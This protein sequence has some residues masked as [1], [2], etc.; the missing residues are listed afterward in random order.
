MTGGNPRPKK[1]H[2]I[3]FG[4]QMNVADSELL[5]GILR[6]K[7]LDLIG[8]P[9]EA[10]LIV[11]NTCT[12]RRKAEDKAYSQMGRL[13]K[14]KS[15][16]GP[17]PLVAMAGCVAKK[18]GRDL[19]R[20]FPGLDIVLSP[21]RVPRVGDLLDRRLETGQAV[22]D[23]GDRPAGAVEASPV[24]K[25]EVKAFVNIMHGCDNHCAYC[26]V[27]AVRGPEVS[28]PPGDVLEEVTELADRGYGEVTLLGQNVNSYGKGLDEAIDFPGLLERLD[29]RSGM[30]RLRFTTSHPKDFDSRLV[31]AIRDLPSVCEAVHLPVQAGSDRVLRAMNRK[32]GPGEYRDK[33]NLL[34]E[35]V[36][37]VRISTDII[38]GYPGE[39]EGDFTATWE[40]V[41]ETRFVSLF[42]FKFSPREGTAA[43]RLEDDVPGAEKDRRLQAILDLQRGISR[44]INEGMVG[45]VEEVLVEGPSKTDPGMMTGRTRGNQ[46]VN[47]PGKQGLRG[48]LRPVEINGAGTHCL[49]GR[50]V[51]KAGEK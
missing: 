25:S 45:R 23:I 27:P 16:R 24:R 3:T 50:F 9:D 32:Y 43:A 15:R 14:M 30:E 20:R 41:K 46:V 49:M 19:L 37:G 38:V 18:E 40:L 22:V 34:R 51:G 5:S 36:P 28:R 4:C 10:D 29:K 11:V 33:V 47:M 31:G 44:E 39:T 48:R 42:A 17:V 6:E 7:G 8:S 26:V 35:A 1:A 21:G 13:M 12:I 2:V